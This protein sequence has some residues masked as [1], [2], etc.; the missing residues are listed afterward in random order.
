VSSFTIKEDKVE[1]F[2]KHMNNDV[3]ETR[4]E[5]GCVRSELMRSREKKNVFYIN[6]TYMN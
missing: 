3:N 5:P 1:E 4:K 2:L 6:D